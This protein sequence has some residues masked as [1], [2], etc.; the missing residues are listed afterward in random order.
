LTFR[1]GIIATGTK[2]GATEYEQRTVHTST[3][4]IP[5]TIGFPPMLK[6]RI[7]KREIRNT[8]QGSKLKSF[9]NLNFRIS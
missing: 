3:P 8:I 6:I 5:N 2:R 1:L 4:E 9:C 7:P